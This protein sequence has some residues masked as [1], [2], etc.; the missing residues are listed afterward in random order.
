MAL[1]RASVIFFAGQPHQNYPGLTLY[2]S[3]TNHPLITPLLPPNHP[4]MHA[5]NM[6]NSVKRSGNIPCFPRKNLHIYEKC[7]IFASDFEK[8]IYYE[9]HSFGCMAHTCGIVCFLL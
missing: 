8:P 5:F 1:A 3:P 2:K 9:E 6:V 7:C 4:L